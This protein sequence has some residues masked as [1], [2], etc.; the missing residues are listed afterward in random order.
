[1]ELFSFVRFH[2]RAGSESAAE[3]ALRNVLSASRQEAGCLSMHIYRSTRDPR[4][5]YIHS[6]WMN[7]DAF[8]QHASLPHTVHFLELMDS[9]IDQ[10]RDVTRTEL[11]G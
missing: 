5:F 1:M 7:E 11:I 6:Q 2:V 9:L 3:E 4:L 10:P 8:E